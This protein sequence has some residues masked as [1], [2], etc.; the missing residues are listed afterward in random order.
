M[1]EFVP[2]LFAAPGGAF[3]N[4]GNTF[5]QEGAI[6]GWQA[7]GIVVGTAMAIICAI[8]LT[9]RLLRARKRRGNR[10]QRPLGTDRGQGHQANGNSKSNVW[11][12][13]HL[14]VAS[15]RPSLRIR[16]SRSPMMNPGRC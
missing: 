1:N 14:V 8:W 11:R 7:I 12:Q 9:T 15:S 13:A 3:S 4:L 2:L 5:H 10:P 6:V 16:P